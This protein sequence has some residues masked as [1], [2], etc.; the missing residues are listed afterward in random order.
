M[1][2][3]RK[4]LT[5]AIDGHWMP[6]DL[7]RFCH[8]VV[9]FYRFEQLFYLKSSGGPDVFGDRFS[10]VVLKYLAA[11]D[12]LA[13]PL[14][15]TGFNESYVRSEDFVREFGVTDL[16]VARVAYDATG[17]GPGE[18]AFAGIGTIVDTIHDALETVLALRQS[19]PFIGDA[20][21]GRF[22]DIEAM[23]A[24]N[25]KLKAGRMAKMGYSDAELHAIV[26]PSVEDLQFI[27][28]ASA[29]G[30]ILGV[31]KG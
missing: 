24:A 2:R 18:I 22:A 20:S 16:R 8:L 7:A 30:K 10:P 25:I 31:E 29:Q 11:F 26:S 5:L 15:S 23:Y 3:D 12:W 17:D 21:Q 1:D 6:L 19:S 13:A 9:R 4:L 14:M 28:N 27:S